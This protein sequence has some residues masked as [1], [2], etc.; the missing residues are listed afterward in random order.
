MLSSGHSTLYIFYQC[1]SF[2]FM[3]NHRF[4]M[5]LC[6]II[7]LV[8]MTPEVCPKK[9]SCSNLYKNRVVILDSNVLLNIIQAID[10]IISDMA[11]LQDE[12]FD[13][14]IDVLKDFLASIRLCAHNERIHVSREVFNEEMNPMNHMS[15]MRQKPLFNAICGNNNANYRT[16][17][18]TLKQHLTIPSSAVRGSEIAKIKRL[19]RSSG[20]TRFNMPSDNDLGLLALTLKLGRNIGGVLLTDDTNLQEALETIQRSRYIT[21]SGQRLDTQ[22]IVYASSLSYLGELYQCCKLL[23]PRFFAVYNVL[24]NFVK[25]ASGSFSTH[26][27][28]TYERLFAQVIRSIR[29]M[30]KQPWRM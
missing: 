13:A 17:D 1:I 3:S 27:I 22:K 18:R 11:L 23:P 28:R 12:R 9:R 20:S 7:T 4:N 2:K 25:S 15:T 6:L 30:P 8:W 14:F 19:L 24:F 16:V 26:T 29:D 10:R 21:L 5:A